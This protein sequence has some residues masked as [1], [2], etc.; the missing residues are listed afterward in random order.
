MAFIN[1]NIN[2]GVLH[3]IVARKMAE[4]PVDEAG[5]QQA[6]GMWSHGVL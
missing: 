5:V 6:A 4:I 3:H 2:T 1:F